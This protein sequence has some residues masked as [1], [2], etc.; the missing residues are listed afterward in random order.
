MQLGLAACGFQ[1]QHGIPCPTCGMT[2]AFAYAADGRLW[3]SLQA[4]P[5]GLIL[6]VVNAA[7]VVVALWGLITGGN[8]IRVWQSLLTKGPLLTL[9]LAVG[10]T[11]GVKVLAATAS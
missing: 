11:W 5:A 7:L 1:Q 9:G 6:A 3:S 2:T 4:Q 10:L 8:V